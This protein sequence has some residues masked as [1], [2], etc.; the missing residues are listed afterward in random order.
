MKKYG[1]KKASRPFPRIHRVKCVKGVACGQCQEYGMVTT[2]SRRSV[3]RSQ[4]L[5]EINEGLESHDFD[6]NVEI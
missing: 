1:A 4:E 5:D 3:E 2:K 6:L